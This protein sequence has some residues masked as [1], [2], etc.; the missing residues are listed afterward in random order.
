MKLALVQC[1]SSANIEAN[2]AM[3]SPMIAHAARQGAQLVATPEN[4]FY[5]ETSGVKLPAYTQDNH[6]GLLAAQEWART[7][8]I[9]ILVGS[10]FCAAGADKSYNRSLLIDPKGKVSAAYDKIHLFD[11]EV[12]DGQI[13][14]ESARI[15]PGNKVIITMLPECMLGMTVCY[16]VRFPHLYR[17][18]AKQGAQ[19]IAVPAAFTQITGEAHWHILLRAR[20]IENGCFIIAPAQTG[21]HAGG[22]R[23]YGHSL[24]VDPW[25]TIIADGGTEPGVTV[26]DIDLSEVEKVR[27]KLPSLEHD[28]DYLLPT[29]R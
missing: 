16:D 17:N 4:S 1:T 25:G 18:L 29:I 6:P 9:W 26:V 19:L 21:E 27:K 8:N 7:H 3:L 24:V 22:R 20:A 23:T 11:V 5:M 28:R 14:R 13:Y 15:A 12:G 10:I 2:I